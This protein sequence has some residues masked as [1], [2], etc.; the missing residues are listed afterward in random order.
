MNETESLLRRLD[1]IG[2]S[3]SQKSTALALIGL[4]SVGVE[5]DRLDRYS[6]LDFFV[7]VKA[8]CKQQYI[9]NLDWLTD[10]AAVAY[11]FPNT[12]DGYKLLFEDGIFCE[13]AVFEEAELKQIAFAPG[14]VVWKAA[15]FD[16]S[17]GVPEPAGLIAQPRSKEW[18]IGEAITNIYVGLLRDQRGER[19]SAMRF[20]QGYAVDRILELSERL[21]TASDGHQDKFSPERRYEL[22]YP[23]MAQHLPG[24]LQGYE[25]N[26]ESALAALT[27]L[28][29]HFVINEAMKEAVLRL[30]RNDL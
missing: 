29:E 6:D 16:E 9:H 10:V 11:T 18:L 1:S 26:R 7:I 21:E 17:L 27:F 4:G 25:R 12:E 14:R 8:G 2:E 24:L 22:R 23:G 19:L 30:C 15:G 5:L 13:F 3:L 28:D 20:I